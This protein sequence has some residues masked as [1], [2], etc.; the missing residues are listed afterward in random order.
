MGGCW[1]FTQLWLQL[2][3]AEFWRPRLGLSREGTDWEHVLQ[4]LCC[5]RLLDPGSEWRLHRVWFEQCALDELLGEDFSIAAKDTLHRCHDLLLE[6]KSAL[7][8]FLRQRWEDLFKVKFDI[9]LY[10]LTSTY[11]E[12]SPPLDPVDKRKC[13]YSRDKRSDC[14]QVV[15]ALVVTPE[16]FPLAYEVM[17][18]NTSDKTTLKGFLQKI[19]EQYGKAGRI[20]IMDRAF[21][22]K[23]PWSRCAVAIRQSTIWWARP[24]DGSTSWKPSCWNWPGSRRAKAWRSNSCPAQVNLTCWPAPKTEWPRS[25]PCAGASSKGSGLAWPSCSAWRRLATRCCSN[26]ARPNS[27]RPRPGVWCTLK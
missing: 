19:E 18:G 22:P 26:W 3:L 4:V 6:H 25:E 27:S 14:L 16:G 7:F 2:G 24:K 21:L 17:A 15:I 10:D 23:K 5:Y 8:G 11:F 13:G 9:L 1:L 12:S 20:W